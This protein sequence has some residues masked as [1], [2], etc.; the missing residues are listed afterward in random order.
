M[1]SNAMPTSMIPTGTIPTGMI[2][3]STMFTYDFMQNAFAAAGVVAV[4][5]GLVGFFLVLR[6]QTFAGHALSHVGFAGA[7]GAVLLG[8]SPLWGLVALT[9]VAGIGMGLLGE[10]LHQRDVAIGIVL[11]MSLGLGLLFLHFFTAYATQATALLFGNILGVDAA[12]VWTLLLL[13][14]AAIAALA[15]ISRPLLFASLQPEL[16]EAKGVSLRTV[17]VLFLAV[18]A[19]A[20]AQCA[21]IVGVLLVFALMV[22]PAAAAQRITTRFWHGIALSV[23]LA[24]VEAWFGLVLAFVTDW[25]TS[26]WITALSG[27][28]YLATVLLSDLSPASRKVAGSVVLVLALAQS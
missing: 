18:V 9:L 2:M 20:V 4:V 26:F 27:S 17:S 1:M 11:A 15:A 13:G 25:P 5:C 8:I 16:A 3:A 14:I 21:Q 10:R 28:I 23:A 22:G 6:A 24:L 7:T 19:L 12:T